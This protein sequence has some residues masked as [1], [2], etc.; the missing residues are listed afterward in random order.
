M[1]TEIP[2]TSQ[3]LLVG[4]ITIAVD[5]VCYIYVHHNICSYQAQ[6]T[7][8]T[9]VVEVNQYTASSPSSVI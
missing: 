7:H 9:T 6:Q 5:V 4:K 1:W 2:S 3:S 8:F